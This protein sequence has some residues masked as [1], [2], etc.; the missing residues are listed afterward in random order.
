MA[1]VFPILIADKAAV[2]SSAAQI[3]LHFDL[4][5]PLLIGENVAYFQV[6]NGFGVLYLALI[7]AVLPV[8]V[9]LLFLRVRAARDGFA[10]SPTGRLLA[11]GLIFLAGTLVLPKSMNGSAF[12]AVRLW[13]PLWL[14][15]AAC[16]A[17]LIHSAAA[18]RRV[19]IWSLGGTFFAL[20]FAMLYVP[21]VARAQAA[22]E[23]APLPPHARGLYLLPE[24]AV[25]GHWTH[26]WWGVNFWGG[27]RAFN[28]H[29]D[30]LINT[31]WM[32]LTILPV[33]ENGRAGLLRDFKPGKESEAPYMAVKNMTGTPASATALALADFVLV[34]DPPGLPPAPGQ[35]AAKFSGA[36]APR[37]RCTPYG[38]YAVCERR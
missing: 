30:V 35:S 22:L 18:E 37:W 34:S 7:V 24:D 25:A 4:I 16:A 13:Y 3:G 26:T 17:A 28:A 6:R 2:A 29:G 33:E 14:L 1:F 32:E 38:A 11:A 36:E 10:L 5:A 12:F 23:Q 20:L 15:I 9:W 21:P 31:P 19:L 27:V 8:G